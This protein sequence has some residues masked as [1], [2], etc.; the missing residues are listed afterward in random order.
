MKTTYRPET[1]QMMQRLK[2]SGF[3]VWA[4]IGIFKRRSKLSPAIP[5]EVIQDV[6]LEYFKRSDKIKSGFPYFLTV[7]KSKSEAY[8]SNKNVIEGINIKQ[9]PLALKDIMKKLAA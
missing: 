4:M 7:L 5:D 3:N 9:E 8:F 6:C 1:E 2:D